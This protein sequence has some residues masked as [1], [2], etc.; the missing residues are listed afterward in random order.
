MFLKLPFIQGVQGDKQSSIQNNAR[1][2][3]C[4]GRDVKV[5]AW[6][7][8]LII[9]HKSCLLFDANAMIGCPTSP[10][11]CISNTGSLE[12][13]TCGSIFAKKL[14]NTYQYVHHCSLQQKLTLEAIKQ[15]ALLIVSTHNYDYRADY[16]L[17]KACFHA[18]PCTIML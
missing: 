12:K 16:G 18:A 10:S 13:C 5:G 1:V 9:G 6:R 8:V 2:G 14:Q 3:I 4:N 17:L 15:Q 11:T 7:K